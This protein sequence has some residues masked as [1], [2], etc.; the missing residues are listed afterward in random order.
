MLNEGAATLQV[1]S[2]PSFTP[3]LLSPFLG[4][5]LLL[6]V[7]WLLSPDGQ[8][9]AD[10]KPG[11]VAPVAGSK[12]RYEVIQ[13]LNWTSSEMHASVG[14]LFNKSLS[15]EIKDYALKKYLT[16]LQYA[17]DNIA[18]GKDYVVGNDFTIADSVRRH[19]TP[20]LPRPP[21][22]SSVS[23]LASHRMIVPRFSTHTNAVLLDRTVVVP[24]RRREP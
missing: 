14:P 20:P 4:S 5:F 2:S 11:S 23:F 10:Q 7:V 16:K 24:V 12:E 17:N 15:D 9:I 21:D 18:A 13:L 1:L 6:L 19:G 3:L 22:T 8:W